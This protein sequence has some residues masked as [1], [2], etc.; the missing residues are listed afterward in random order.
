MI[1]SSKFHI[2][3]KTSF[4][5]IAILKN[6]DCETFTEC[7][8]VPDRT[9]TGSSKTCSGYIYCN[10][11][12]SFEGQ[13]DDASYFNDEEKVCDDKEF[14]DCHLEDDGDTSTST[15]ITTITTISPITSSTISPT[16]MANTTNANNV[17]AATTTVRNTTTVV[18]NTSTVISTLS[19]TAA[20]IISTTP[21]TTITLTECPTVD[22]PFQI[23]F[24]A[25]T[26]SCSE[27]FVCFNGTPL[28]MFCSG[29]LHFNSITGKCDYPENVRCLV[30]SS[31]LYVLS[32]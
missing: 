23:V 18:A 15:T 30:C 22:N 6:V 24:L 28:E 11:D 9:F 20:T 29:M 19:T 3:I 32:G 8:N 4:V 5:L 21:T 10:G 16:S 12:E 31:L 25:S 27:Y 17:T 1:F 2:I 26:I 13:C 14:V 7:E